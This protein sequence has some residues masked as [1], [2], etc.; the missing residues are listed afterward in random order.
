MQV[1][2]RSRS[3]ESEPSRNE[4]AP[5]RGHLVVVQL[6]VSKGAEVNKQDKKYG[7]PL[8]AALEGYMGSGLTE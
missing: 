4:N 3:K 5:R 6:L 7:C 2:R 1:L 8:I